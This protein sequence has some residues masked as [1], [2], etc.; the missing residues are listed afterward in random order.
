MAAT[1]GALPR[2][3][4]GG[5]KTDA[6]LPALRCGPLWMHTCVDGGAAVAARDELRE[7]RY[8]PLPAANDPL[9]S[10]DAG[11]GGAGGGGA[12]GGSSA[13]QYAL[14]PVGTIRREEKWK[15]DGF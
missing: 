14:L 8:L 13:A 15:N 2:D 7:A 1:G 9:A 10:S 3:H 6:T 4:S 11:G 12:G 5:V